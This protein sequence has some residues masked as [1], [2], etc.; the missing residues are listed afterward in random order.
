[1]VLQPARL[2]DRAIQPRSRDHTA[3]RPH[4][5]P[6]NY[7]YAVT[8]NSSLPNDHTVISGRTVYYQISFNHREFFVK[9]SDVLVDDLP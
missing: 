8:I 6:D 3:A 9:A 2:A 1:M 4:Q 5:V 7:Y